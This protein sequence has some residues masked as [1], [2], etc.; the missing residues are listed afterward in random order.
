MLELLVS[1]AECP[2][3]FTDTETILSCKLLERH[4]FAVLE[5]QEHYDTYICKRDATVEC[6]DKIK[7]SLKRQSLGE[8]AGG[9]GEQQQIELCRH[10]YKLHFQ[11]L[12][13]FQSYSKLVKLLSTAANAPQVTD[14]SRDATDLKA[15][16]HQAIYDVDNG[17]V[18][19]LGQVDTVSLSR[20]VAEDSLLENLKNGQ[21][22]T[23]VQLIRAFRSMWPNLVFGSAD[24][25]DMEYL[26]ALFCKH[27]ADNKTGVLV[28][29]RADTDLSGVCHRLMEVNIQLL[30]SLKL[31]E[32]PPKS[33]QSSP[34]SPSPTTN[35]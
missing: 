16:L 20:Q 29:T 13:L 19:P 26:L 8:E 27:V 9:N 7:E 12:L 1:Q 33:P 25:D 28:M 17:S 5:I 32:L 4:K 3:I 24:E 10:L 30:S 34:S 22:T 14:Y 35:L 2:H 21:L 11:L 23:C 15:R 6:L 18:L 31:L